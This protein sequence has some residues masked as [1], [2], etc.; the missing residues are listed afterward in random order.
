MK[1]GAILWY[2]TSR[3]Q[4]FGLRLASGIFEGSPGLMSTLRW[5]NLYLNKK[6]GLIV[7]LLAMAAEKKSPHHSERL[8]VACFT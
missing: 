1:T 3:R 4:S 7:K 6:C 5:L 8:P 2:I